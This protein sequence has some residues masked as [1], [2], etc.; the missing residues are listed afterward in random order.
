MILLKTKT[1]GFFELQEK[2]ISYMKW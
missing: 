1:V 2:V